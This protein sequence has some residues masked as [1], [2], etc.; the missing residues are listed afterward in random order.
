MLEA[1]GYT[2]LQHVSNTMYAT[3]DLFSAP[4]Q[5]CPLD[6]EFARHMDE[7]LE[8]LILEMKNPQVPFEKTADVDKCKMCDFRMICGR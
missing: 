2:D 4:P 6:P 8:K 3:A 7:R 5:V 1:K